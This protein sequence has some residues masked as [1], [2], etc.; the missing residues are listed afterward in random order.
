MEP[1]TLSQITEAQAIRPR[2]NNLESFS[3]NLYTSPEG[4]PW[5]KIA[6]NSISTIQGINLAAKPIEIY[7]N[8]TAH[9]DI[10][11]AWLSPDWLPHKLNR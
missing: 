3:N 8:V 4:F 5:S 2:Q 7:S 11:L 10:I 6:G 9:D 1:G